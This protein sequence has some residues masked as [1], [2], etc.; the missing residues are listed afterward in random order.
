MKEGGIVA[1]Q[2]QKGQDGSD[3]LVVASE[4][5]SSVRWQLQHVEAVETIDDE[6]EVFE[7]KN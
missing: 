5:N 6:K 2:P 7:E 3:V 1:A 4:T